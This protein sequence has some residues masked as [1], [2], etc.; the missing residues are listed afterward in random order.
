MKVNVYRFF[1]EVE[2]LDLYFLVISID[3]LGYVFS[4]TRRIDYYLKFPTPNIIKNFLLSNENSWIT[5]KYKNLDIDKLK[6]DYCYNVIKV[7]SF[8][9]SFCDKELEY[10]KLKVIREW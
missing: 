5:A 4:T 3:E 9:I 8:D 6:T 2:G 7:G 1:E 10:F